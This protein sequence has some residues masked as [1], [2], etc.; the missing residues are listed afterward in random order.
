MCYLPIEELNPTSPKYEPEI[1][2]AVD[3]DIAVHNGTYKEPAEIA[4]RRRFSGKNSGG[5]TR[6]GQLRQRSERN[7]SIA[8]TKLGSL[9]LGKKMLGE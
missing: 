3:R 1:K 8:T 7:S 6:R 2:A 4:R 5:K 9:F